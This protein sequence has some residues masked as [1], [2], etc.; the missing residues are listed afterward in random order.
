[1]KQVDEE[2][3]SHLVLM[4]VE[5]TLKKHENDFISVE[6]LKQQIKVTKNDA[7]DFLNRWG[8]GN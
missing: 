6:E 8:E 5:S 7:E 4:S 2:M 1:M 3:I